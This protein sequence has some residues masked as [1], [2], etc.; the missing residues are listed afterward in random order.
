MANKKKSL[1][2]NCLLAA[3]AVELRSSTA[4]D[5]FEEAFHQVEEGDGR[6]LFSLPNMWK[7]EAKRLEKKTML[8]V[9][10]SG[11]WTVLKQ[12]NGT[13]NS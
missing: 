3:H 5:D 10:I 8:E 7:E 9:D 11:K 12:R 2:T 6:L 13:Q 1:V 4:D